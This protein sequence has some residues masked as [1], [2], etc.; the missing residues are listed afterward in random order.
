MLSQDKR[1]T[2]IKKDELVN[3]VQLDQDFIPPFEKITSVAVVPFTEDGKIITTILRDRGI[4]IPGGHILKT[5][6]N[7]K[8]TVKREAYEEAC[9]TLRDIKTIKI[10]QSDYYGKSPD[11]L[12]YMVITTAIVDKIE[13][14]TPNKESSGRCITS[15][16]DF[17]SR[18]TAGDSKNMKELVLSAQKIMFKK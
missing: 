10:I 4:D 2:I 12:T 8:E 13:T 3:F 18:Y 15:V 6:N 11:K 9:I 17:L 1:K 5:E 7:I 16:E 14:F